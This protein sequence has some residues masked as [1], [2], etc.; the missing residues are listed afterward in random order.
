MDSQ[1]IYIYGTTYDVLP[2]REIRCKING[3]WTNGH[4]VKKGLIDDYRFYP[5]NTLKNQEWDGKTIK[6]SH[7][8]YYIIDHNMEIDELPEYYQDR[9]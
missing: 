8:G 9:S 2:R 4:I 5:S 3:V 7:V 6:D 1:F